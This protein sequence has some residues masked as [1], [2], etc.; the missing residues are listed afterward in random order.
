MSNRKARLVGLAAFAVLLIVALHHTTRS[1]TPG[2]LDVDEKAETLLRASS[3]IDSNHDDK[4]DAAINQQISQ[5]GNVND[6]NAA[7][8]PDENA[9]DEAFDAEKELITIRAHSPM[10]IFSKTFCPYSKQLKSLLQ[11]SYQITPQPAIVE[12]DKHK[13]GEELQKY[14]EEVTG[15]RTVPNVLVGKSSESRGGADDFMAL[16]QSGELMLQLTA[17]GEKLIDVTQIEAPSNV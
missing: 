3:L 9:S 10:V 13:H 2:Q 5:L 14:L 15:R 8:K 16:H 1:S 4:L 17:W 7:A 6:A 11:E 12:L